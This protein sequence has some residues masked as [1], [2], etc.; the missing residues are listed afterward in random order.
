MHPLRGLHEHLPGLPALWRAELWGDL[1]GTDRVDHRSDV[2]RAE[3]QQPAFRIHAERQLHQ[4]LSG[5]DQ[6]SRADLRLRKLLVRQHETPFVKRAAMKAAGALFAR[7]AVYRA[8]IE[9]T[10]EAL[11]SLPRFVIY[12]G[13]NAWGKGREMPHPPAQTFHQWYNKNRGGKP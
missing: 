3:I 10:N 12:N 11:A 2:Q 13:L 4:R 8:A 5:E 6:Y 9:R 1:F 7:P